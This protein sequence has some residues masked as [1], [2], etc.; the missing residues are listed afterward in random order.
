[1]QSQIINVLII[2]DDE[3]ICS[4]LSTILNDEGYAVE[5]A[6][7]GKQANKTCKKT[8]FDVALIDNVL[9]DIN[10]TE[11]LLK[12]KQIQPKMAN[13]FITGHPS[14]ENAVKAIDE[15]ADG[16]V[17]K[18]IDIPLLLRTIKKTLTD[19]QNEYFQMFKEVENEKR[20][21]QF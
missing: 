3:Q 21:P 11:L 6:K 13:I 7:T 17:L 1:M 10:G 16:Y 15:K 18:P 12:L 19:K 8:T 9:P 14:I 5:T 20:T 4:S 2:D